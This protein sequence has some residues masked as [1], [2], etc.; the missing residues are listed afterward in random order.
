MLQ[1]VRIN[2]SSLQSKGK[3]PDS[4]R[5]NSSSLQSKGKSP[6]SENELLMSNEFKELL[7]LKS[8][9]TNQNVSLRWAGLAPTRRASLNTQHFK[10]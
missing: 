10:P 5:I 8:K 4:E 1:N 6:D 2:S 3:S 9:S 7:C